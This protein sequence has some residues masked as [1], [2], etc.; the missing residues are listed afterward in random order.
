L[1]HLLTAACGT[2]Q[3]IQNVRFTAGFGGSPDI[4]RISLKD[5]L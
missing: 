1:L 5:R 3:P 4:A 2:N